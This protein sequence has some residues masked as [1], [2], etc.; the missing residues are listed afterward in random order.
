[1]GCNMPEVDMNLNSVILQLNDIGAKIILLQILY[2]H[3]N[4]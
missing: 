3:V 2:C 1:M 4:N